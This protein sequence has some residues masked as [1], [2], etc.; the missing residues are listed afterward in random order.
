MDEM[1][2]ALLSEGGTALYVQLVGSRGQ[3][4][5]PRTVQDHDKAPF[6]PA[7]L[8]FPALLHI[9]AIPSCPPP[10]A[11]PFLEGQ[12]LRLACPV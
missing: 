10:F 2:V 6:L 8:T 5:Q 11:L 9:L 12:R 3:H 4:A 1:D 7:A